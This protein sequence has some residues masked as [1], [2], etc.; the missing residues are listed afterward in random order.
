MSLVASFMKTA[1]TATVSLHEL[2]SCSSFIYVDVRGHT[3]WHV[4]IDTTP[5]KLFF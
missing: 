2:S 4:H 3:Y 5:N 1:L